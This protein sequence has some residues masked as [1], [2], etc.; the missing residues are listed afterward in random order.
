MHKPES[1]QENETNKIM[2]FWDPNESTYPGQRTRSSIDL[3]EKINLP[4][5]GFCRSN[6]PQS[7]N[8]RKEKDR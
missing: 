5:D 8:K 2:W 7:E 6:W 3:Q 1:V 4:S